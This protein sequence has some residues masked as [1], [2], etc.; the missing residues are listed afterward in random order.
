[1]ISVANSTQT[2]ARYTTSNWGK[3]TVDLA[4]P[5]ASI[6]GLNITWNGNTNDI[7]NYTPYTGTSQA[8]A[9]VTGTIALLKA[10]YGW[11]TANGLRDR[12]LMATDNLTDS[13][14]TTHDV[15]TH[16][17]LNVNKAL[18]PRTLIRNISTRARVESGDK[19]MIGGFFISDTTGGAGRLK[20]AIRGLGP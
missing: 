19:I 10:Q 11:E 2:D 15:R 18:Q 3:K 9:H 6:Y 16:G 17:R 5:G 20:V 1:M 4:A 8:A 7:N 12:V 14:W 13:S